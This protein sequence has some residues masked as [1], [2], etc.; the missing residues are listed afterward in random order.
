[1]DK[2]F[3]Q[4][5]CIFLQL[6][7]FPVSNSIGRS[8]SCRPIDSFVFDLKR[9]FSNRENRDHTEIYGLKIFVRIYSKTGDNFGYRKRDWTELSSLGVRAAKRCAGA[10]IAFE[11][12]VLM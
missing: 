2:I 10:P 12:L 1:M 9:I 6:E 4:V 7:Y 5:V 8:N 11:S 3:E